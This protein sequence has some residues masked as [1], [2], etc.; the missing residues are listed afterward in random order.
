MKFYLWGEASSKM[1]VRQRMIGL[2]YTILALSHISTTMSLLITP[3]ALLSGSPLVIYS[4]KEELRVLLRLAFVC[5]A[6]EWL[7]DCIVSLIT[8]Y[9][10]A[11][12]EGHAAYWISPCK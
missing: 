5:M 8:G 4:G 10:I 6:A 2:I 12:C 11:I 9:R 7:D 1:T 3:V